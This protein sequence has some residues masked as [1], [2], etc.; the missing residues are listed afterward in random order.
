M[1][2]LRIDTRGTEEELKD[3]IMGYLDNWTFHGQISEEDCQDVEA[4]L[5][6]MLKARRN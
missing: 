2:M 6:A 1:K 5:A 4:L 3:R